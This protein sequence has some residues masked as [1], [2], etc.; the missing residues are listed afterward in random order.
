MYSDGEKESEKK[1][2]K[3]T[4]SC[5]KRDGGAQYPGL[6]RSSL[7][8]KWDKKHAFFPLAQSSLS[9]HPTG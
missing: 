7:E 1:P 2:G 5:V 6:R 8:N 4:L 9:T 3:V